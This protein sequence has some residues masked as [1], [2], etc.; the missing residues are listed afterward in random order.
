MSMTDHQAHDPINEAHAHL[1]Q[2]SRVAIGSILQL[3]ELKARRG[4]NRAARRRDEQAAIAKA[5]AAPLERD[6]RTV[7]PA[8]T[9]AEPASVASDQGEPWRAVGDDSWW[10]S[11]TGEDLGTAWVAASADAAAGNVDAAHALDEM[12]HQVA[13][14]WGVSL[15]EGDAVVELAQPSVGAATGTAAGTGEGALSVAPESVAASPTSAVVGSGN[16]PL[17]GVSPPAVVVPDT[18][19]A[20]LLA[21][22]PR[23]AARDL[24]AAAAAQAGDDPS[25]PARRLA[26]AQRAERDSG[27]GLG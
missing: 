7:A 25:A 21:A 13:E 15:D 19:E 20:L 27:A 10:A 24:A 26:M 4:A 11:A 17:P 8:G 3:A 6:Y 16:V 12:K 14:R 18:I 1:D 5:S 22:H 2:L 23:S 9:A